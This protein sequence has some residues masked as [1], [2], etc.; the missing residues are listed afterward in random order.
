MNS[1][2]ACAFVVG[3]VTMCERKSESHSNKNKLTIYFFFLK[4]ERVLLRCAGIVAYLKRWQQKLEKVKA[5]TIAISSKNLAL[6]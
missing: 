1:W 6:T 5:T 3:V 4:K 2:K